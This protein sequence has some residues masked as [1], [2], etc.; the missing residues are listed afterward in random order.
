[1]FLQLD[2]RDNMKQYI[3]TIQFAAGVSSSLTITSVIELYISIIFSG[4]TYDVLKA[5]IGKKG[6]S[7]MKNILLLATS[8]LGCCLG[9]MV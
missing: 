8:W 6:E 4:V 5:V 7:N 3:N 2:K 9:D 1:M